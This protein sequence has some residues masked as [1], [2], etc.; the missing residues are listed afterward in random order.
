MMGGGGSERSEE[1]WGIEDR[2]VIL[3]NVR[4]SGTAISSSAGGH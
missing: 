2:A 4:G 1:I 3:F